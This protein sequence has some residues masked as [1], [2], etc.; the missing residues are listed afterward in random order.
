M[1]SGWAGLRT[2]LRHPWPV[3]LLI[4]VM[5]PV[6]VEGATAQVYL[7]AN[8]GPHPLTEATFQYC[9]GALLRCFPQRGA[10]LVSQNSRCAHVVRGHKT[11]QAK[12]NRQILR[13]C[14]SNSCCWYPCC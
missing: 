14:C 8:R 7:P 13:A 10:K 5:G 12:S 9:A 2:A 4:S 3:G 1:P 11:D 6:D